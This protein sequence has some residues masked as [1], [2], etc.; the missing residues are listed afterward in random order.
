MIGRA[1][2][3]RAAARIAGHVRRTPVLEIADAALGAPLVLKLELLQ[4]TG[5]FKVRGAFNRLLDAPRHPAGVVAAS[6]G[7]HGLGVAHAA[8]TLGLRAEIFVPTS[9]PPVKV[10]RLRALGADVTVTG[11]FYADA[12]AASATRAASTGALVVHAYD[13]PEV[14]AGQ[15]TLALELE[16]QAPALDTVLVAV[17]GGGL[18]AGIAAALEGRCRV[19]AVEPE[20]CPTLHDALAAQ[21]PVEVTVG[22]VAADSLGARRIGDVCFAVARRT[23]MRS[24]LVGDDAIAR[25]RRLL[26]E[27]LRVTAE[28]G[29]ATALAALL[30]GAYTPVAGERVA[31]VVSGGNTDPATLA[32]RPTGAD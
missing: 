9:S 21:R 12:L 26:W 32:P 27:E 7:N 2:V 29:G 28:H 24:L 20:H 6:G 17:G 8:R 13:Q 4:A 16:Q 3:E 14:A 5:S 1:D 19:V 30:C 15:G 31:V 23:G 25:A 11:A 22:G 10:E 18:V